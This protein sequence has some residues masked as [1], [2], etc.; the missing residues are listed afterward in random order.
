[1][2]KVGFFLSLSFLF[3]LLFSWVACAFTFN[4]H[5]QFLMNSEVGMAQ[6]PSP[7]Y[8]TERYKPKIPYRDARNPYICLFQFFKH[9]FMLK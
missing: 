6:S 8:R 9:M 3:C 1:M 2:E 5:E 4:E 7:R